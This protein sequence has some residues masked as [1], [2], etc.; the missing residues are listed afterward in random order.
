[1]RASAA[2]DTTA[3]RRTRSDMGNLRK[4]KERKSRKE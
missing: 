3:M 4:R 1:V 2:S